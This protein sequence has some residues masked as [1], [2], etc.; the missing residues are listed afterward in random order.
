MQI[1]KVKQQENG[2]LVN[3]TMSVP[4]AAGNR[5][6]QMVQEWIAQGNT[7]EPEFTPEELAARQEAEEAAAAEQEAARAE[8]QEFLEW[9][10]MR[11]SV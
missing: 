6:Y 9:K 4:N 2:Y 7:P 5:H 3:D 8:Y 10:A 11:D 1:F